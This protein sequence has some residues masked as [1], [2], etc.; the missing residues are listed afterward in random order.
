MLNRRDD[1]EAKP[2]GGDYDVLIVGAG[3]SGATAAYFLGQKGYKVALIDK[4][5]FPRA[6]PCGDAWCKPGEY[7]PLTSLSLSTS[8]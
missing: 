1:V 5:S 2:R 8:L 3:P 7:L 6:K 4:K